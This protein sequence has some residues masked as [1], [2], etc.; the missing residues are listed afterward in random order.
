MGYITSAD[1]GINP[2]ILAKELS[3]MAALSFESGEMLE[4]VTPVSSET[5]ITAASLSS[6]TPRAALWRSPTIEVGR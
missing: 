2:L 3:E 6:A 1:T 5:T 4:K